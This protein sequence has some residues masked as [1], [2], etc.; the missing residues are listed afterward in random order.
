MLSI[1][2]VETYDPSIVYENKVYLAQEYGYA[3]KAESLPIPQCKYKCL[4]DTETDKFVH[5]VF[6]FTNKKYF[7]QKMDTHKIRYKQ[8]QTDKKWQH[9]KLNTHTGEATKNR[10]K[11]NYDRRYR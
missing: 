9:I 5:D 8:Q 7:Y 3:N 6:E 4:C 1:R 11:E 10:P 2:N